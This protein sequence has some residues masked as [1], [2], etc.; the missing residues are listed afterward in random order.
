MRSFPLRE[1]FL[2][3][4]RLV[5]FFLS[6]KKDKSVSKFFEELKRRNVIK[7][8]IAYLVVAWILIQV[9]SILLDTFNAPDW[10]IQA[11]TIIL[12]IGLPIWIVISWVYDITPKGIEV[13]AKD[14]EKQIAKEITNK[15]LNVFIIVSLSIAVIVLALNQTIF[16]SNPNQEYSIA[17]IPFENIKIDQDKDWLSQNFTQ[18]VN[19]YLS[20][21]KKLRVIDS[22]SARKYKGTDKTNIEIGEELDVSYVL[23][24][25]V[26]QLKGKINVYVEL[27]DVI[28][29]TVYWS[30]SYDEIIEE[31]PLKLQQEVSQKIVAHLKVAL[32]TEDKNALKTLLTSNQE[33]SIFFTEGK[34]IADGRTGKNA[35]SILA[36]SA[37][38][39][40]KAI[41]LDPNFAEAYAEM[42]FGLRMI[43]ED[44]KIF[45]NTDKLKK[46][47]SLL[48]RSLEINPNTV[49]AY[50]TLGMMQSS[51]DKNWK[52]AKEYY[53]KAL[54]IKPN[55]AST[56]HYYAL[57]FAQKPEPDHEKALEHITI[58]HK[59]NPFSAPINVTVILE[60]LSID[61]IEEA[62]AFY[63]N[64]SRGFSD[65]GKFIEG[66][67]M[68]AEIK[69]E[70]FKKKDWREAIKIY[71][72]KI[73]I[74]SNDSDL[75]LRLAKAYNEI[76]N[77]SLNY[78][79][80]AK[81]AYELGRLYSEN[82]DFDWMSSNADLYFSALLKNKKFKEAN[83]L[84]QDDYFKSLFSSQS[85]F[86]LTFYTYYYQGNYSKARASID[87]WIYGN[88]FE[89]TINYAQQNKVKKVDSILNKIS[90][91]GYEKAIVFAILKEKDSMYLH[92][93]KEKDIYTILRF[94]A[95]TEVD[96]Y[97]KEDRY[98]AFLKKN[99]LPI[100]HW[101][102]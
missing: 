43:T 87:S 17:V 55:D 64:N 63:K 100:T 90:F 65:A 14:S 18:N 3:L 12:A 33:A 51:R 27:I 62:K 83:N 102:E 47:D 40:Q 4:M 95:S 1:A 67:I 97:R 96:P 77:N 34:R 10:I 58:A 99:Y 59:L 45:K 98:K 23:R 25:F 81:K 8:T 32:S 2:F 54:V 49:R 31:D 5:I 53:D 19:S 42:A 20:K 84:L 89:L 101:N 66:R 22:Y 11:F 57:Y 56:H 39:F 52:K 86:Y 92:I 28:S 36:S 82:A 29:N 7:A 41:D 15:R 24:G 21:V 93:E 78:L 13:T 91:D 88:T 9:A 16:S 6:L 61:K 48:T 71:H 94:N 26:T 80:Y 76:S 50:T 68:D 30:E 75:C 85:L 38:M 72:R 70:V 73:E 79:K 46:V 44:H 35:D 69:K 60:L 74:D 37:K